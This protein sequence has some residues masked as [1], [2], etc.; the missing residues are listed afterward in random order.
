[1][2]YPNWNRFGTTN[3]SS[4]CVFCGYRMCLTGLCGLI[5]FYFRMVK[6]KSKR[7]LF[8]FNQIIELQIDK[9]TQDNTLALFVKTTISFQEFFFSVCH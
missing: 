9:N 1:M 2:T 6:K 8:F 3:Q 5:I 4:I 7:I